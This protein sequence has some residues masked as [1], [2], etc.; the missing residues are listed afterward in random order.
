MLSEVGQRPPCA[1]INIKLWRNKK[2]GNLRTT[3]IY[4]HIHTRILSNSK[5]PPHRTLRKAVQSRRKSQA[6]P[7]YSLISKEHQHKEP[8]R[9]ATTDAI[10]EICFAFKSRIVP[11]LKDDQTKDSLFPQ[12]R[13]PP[14]GE[15][16]DFM[17]SLPSCQSPLTLAQDCNP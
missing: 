12:A 11:I 17:L 6:M 1:L 5:E 9:G 2:M 4:S 15:F 13:G 8:S 10:L 3:S 16:Q 7:F 14:E